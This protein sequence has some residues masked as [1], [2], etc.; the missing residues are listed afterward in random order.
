MAG[1]RDGDAAGKAMGLDSLPEP[2]WVCSGATLIAGDGTRTT[3]E[4]LAVNID[5]GAREAHIQE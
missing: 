3:D 4:E 2:L 5:G 1:H